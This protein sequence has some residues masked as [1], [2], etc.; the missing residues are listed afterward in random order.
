MA[1]C[2]GKKKYPGVKEAN[3]AILNL[4]AIDY[5]LRVGDLHVYHCKK[6]HCYHVGHKEYYERKQARLKEQSS[7][8]CQDIRH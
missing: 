5:T 7:D 6:C 1:D 4:F 2:R 3:K 8:K